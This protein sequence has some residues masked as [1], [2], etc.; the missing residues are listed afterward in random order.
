MAL[1]LQQGGIG[2]YPCLCPSLFTIDGA[3][4]HITVFLL[5]LFWVGLMPQVTSLKNL[6]M[7]GVILTLELAQFPNN[8]Q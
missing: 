2:C 1:G 5:A 6:K 3:L 8:Q 7:Q 4:S